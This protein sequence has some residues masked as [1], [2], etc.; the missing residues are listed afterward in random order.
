MMALKVVDVNFREQGKYW[1]GRSKLLRNV[2]ECRNVNDIATQVKVKTWQMTHFV[3][4]DA[5]VDVRAPGGPESEARGGLGAV[6]RSR[7]PRGER[8]EKKNGPEEERMD[9]Q[10]PLARSHCEEQE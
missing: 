1:Q 7:R 5:L 9:E 4:D 10:C 3:G 8:S 2:L 6:E